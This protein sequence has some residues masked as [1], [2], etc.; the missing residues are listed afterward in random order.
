ML[1]T[2]KNQFILTNLLWKLKIKNILSKPMT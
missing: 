2:R 1:D